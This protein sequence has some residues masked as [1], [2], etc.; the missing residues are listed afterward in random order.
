M[1]AIAIQH[2]RSSASYPLR[3]RAS[4]QPGPGQAVGSRR[5]SA[6]RSDFR[7]RACRHLRIRLVFVSKLATSAR[8]VTPGCPGHPQCFC[9]DCYPTG[10]SLVSL[11]RFLIITQVGPNSHALYCLSYPLETAISR[12]TFRDSVLLIRSLQLTDQGLL[13]C[14]LLPYCERILC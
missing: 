11:L 1:Y 6:M 5:I 3:C 13:Y 14:G 10:C 4:T 8:L 9:P 12:C 2:E 7:H